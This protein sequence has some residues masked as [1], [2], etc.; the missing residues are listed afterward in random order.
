MPLAATP[1]WFADNVAQITL[2]PLLVLSFL[3]VRL[4]QKAMLRLFLLGLIAAVGLFVYVNRDPLQACARTCECQ[5][6]DREVNVPICDP[7]LEL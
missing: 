1:A 4:V 5:I 6:A 2:V 7:D 3:V